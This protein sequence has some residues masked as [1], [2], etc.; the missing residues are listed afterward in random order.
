MALGHHKPKHPNQQNNNIPMKTLI[1]SV[2]AVA[3][4]L[5]VPGMALAKG[6]NGEKPF[7]GNVTAVD[8]AASTITV[9]K[10]KSGEAKTFNAASAT[11]TVAGASGKLADITVGMKVKVTPGSGPGSASLIDAPA[12]KA[13]GKKGK[14]ST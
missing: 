9:T 10:K 5:I 1:S 14:S 2:L 3:I 4:L 6:K 13:G 8:A 11:V 12:K 7:S